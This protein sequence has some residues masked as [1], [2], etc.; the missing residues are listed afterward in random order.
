MTLIDQI[1]LD[2]KAAM[3][4]RND[5]LLRPLRMLRSAIYNETKAKKC[6][7]TDKLVVT[8]ASRVAGD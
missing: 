1:T 8:I 7:A 2:L 5:E 6:E 3:L 4:A